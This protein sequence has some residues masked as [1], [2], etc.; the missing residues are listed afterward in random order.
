[1][2]FADPVGDVAMLGPPD[3]QVWPKEAAAY[4]ELVNNMGTLRIGDIPK[5]G[6]V[7]LLNLDG[8]WKPA[9][10]TLTDAGL[11]LPSGSTVGGMS[12][13]PIVTTDGATFGLVA[14]GGS[15]PNPRLTERLLR[16]MVDGG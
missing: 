13:S 6:A 4:D 9:A 5:R 1:M 15:G 16:W 11:E 10:A 2:P 3:N 14:C 8:Q 12:G 7:W